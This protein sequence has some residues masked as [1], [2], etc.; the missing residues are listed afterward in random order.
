MAWPPEQHDAIQRA[1]NGARVCVTGGAGFIGSHV[2]ETLLDFGADVAVIDDLSGS[3]SG[4]ISSLLDRHARGSARFVYASIL[5][6]RALIE[7]VSGAQMVFHF[8]A[9]SSPV[10][11]IEDPARCVQVNGLGTARVAEAARKAEVTRMVYAASASAYGDTEG[12]NKESQAP[13]PI[14]PYGASKL[15]GEYTVSAWARSLGLDGVNLRFFNVYGPGQSPDSEY[16]AVIPAFRKRLQAD[17]APTIYGDGE[18]TRDFV[19]I[20][21]IVRAVLLAGAHDHPLGGATI[22]I[23][24]GRAV[25]INELAAL[26]AKLCGAEGL[27]PHHKPARTGDIQASNCDASLAS[28]L[29]GFQT[30]TSLE[31]GL[32]DLLK[33]C[34]DRSTAVA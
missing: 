28:S 11:A 25:S 1:Y 20:S 16:A 9:V 34:R 18:Q 4:R 19:H 26:M 7:A 3:T 6:P 14:S 33:D 15:A 8:A 30:T 10:M 17:Q 5:E 24:S 22:N 12:A 29:L 21:D 13:A 27:A 23:G 32:R 31:D 2:V